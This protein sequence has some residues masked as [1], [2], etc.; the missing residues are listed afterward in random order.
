[1]EAKSDSHTRRHWVS[2]KR[3]NAVAHR[4]E[5]HPRHRRR[6]VDEVIQTGCGTY[7][8]RPILTNAIARFVAATAVRGI[9]L[10][11]DALP[12]TRG[13]SRRTD[14]GA[15]LTLRIE[16]TRPVASTAMQRI[17]HRVDALRAARG[18]QTR[19]DR[20][21][22]GVSARTYV[23][24]TATIE[25]IRRRINAGI[26]TI[27]R[28]ARTNT[29][30]IATRRS[31]TTSIVA[32]TAVI[33]ADRQ[34]DTIGTTPICRRTNASAPLATGQ[35]RTRRCFIDSP[36]AIVVVTVANLHSPSIRVHSTIV[37]I[38]S[39]ANNRSFAVLVFVEDRIRTNR[40][41]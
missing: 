19:A 22:A 10:G 24:T 21:D 16:R 41:A 2:Q 37:A 36:I 26:A 20:V 40:R 17:V 8:A 33:V 30:P 1:M 32:R 39:I 15:V 38:L 18:V 35:T 31:S 11:I 3:T 29:L 7:R 6:I 34:I 28:I 13:L 27:G 23:V 12:I 5:L 14:T 9:G 4:S 25:R